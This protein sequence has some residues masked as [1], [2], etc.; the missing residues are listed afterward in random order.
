MRRLFAFIVLT[1]LVG[2]ATQPYRPYAREVKKKPGIEGIIALKTEHIPEDRAYADTLMARNCG[3]SAVNVLEE[4]E[5]EVGQTTTTNSQVRDEKEA[6][7][8]NF[9]GLKLLTGGTTDVK[10]KAQTSSTMAVKEW[11]INY[12]CKTEMAKARIPAKSKTR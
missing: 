6:N 12:N 4:G 11:Q 5:V 3:Q 2:C 10:N 1:S 7:G 9:G 8:F